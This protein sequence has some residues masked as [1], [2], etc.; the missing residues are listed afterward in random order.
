MLPRFVLGTRTCCCCDCVHENYIFLCSHTLIK[1]QNGVTEAAFM[2]CR[3][4]TSKIDLSLVH[5]RQKTYLSFSSFYWGMIADI[6]IE[7]GLENFDGWK[8]MS[9]RTYRAK[10]SYLKAAYLKN[11]REIIQ[12]FPPLEQETLDE[13]WITIEGN[14]IF[15]WASQ[16]SHAVYNLMQSPKSKPA[17]GLFR[18][19]MVRD[20]CSRFTLAKILTSIRSGQQ[21][22]FKEV[23]C[24]DCVAYRLVSLSDGSNFVLD[25]EIIESG[26]IQACMLPSA[27]NVF[28]QPPP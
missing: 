19:M 1:E 9:V 21:T 23:E 20:H 3:G 24:I 2:I 28:Y 10:F 15:L 18:V 22:A 14:F 13:K 5:T 26:P 16:L 11:I 4:Q 12:N 27:L 25:G 7:S 17:D 6:H 8:A